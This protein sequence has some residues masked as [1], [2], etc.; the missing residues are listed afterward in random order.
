[1]S[2]KPAEGSGAVGALT[3]DFQKFSPFPPP[4]EDAG[5]A[6][7]G[8]ESVYLPAH[9]RPPPPPTGQRAGPNG[10]VPLDYSAYYPPT[11]YYSSLA[12]EHSLESQDSSTLSSPSDCLAQA[13]PAGTGAA[14]GSDSLFQFSIGKILDDESGAPVPAGAASGPDCELPAFYEGVSY[15]EGGEGDM[16]RTSP[17]QLHPPDRPD[18]QRGST[19]PQVKR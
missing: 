17:P 4:L 8:D 14:G 18:A 9:M 6:Q 3:S 7:P 19:D 1:M 5:D 15:P 10:G 2:S 11:D 13:G 16:G 12:K